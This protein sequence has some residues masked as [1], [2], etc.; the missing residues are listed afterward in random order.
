V[1]MLNDQLLVDVSRLMSLLTETLQVDDFLDLE[2]LKEVAQIPPWTPGDLAVPL[3]P[4]VPETFQPAPPTGLTKQCLGQNDDLLIT[5]GA[6]GRPQERHRT[7]AL[8]RPY[9]CAK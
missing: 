1:A 9:S 4:P 3:R 7:C 2:S 6:L 8:A 5:T